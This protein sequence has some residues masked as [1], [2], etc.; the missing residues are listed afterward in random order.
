[1]GPQT[2]NNE[3]I[4]QYDPKDHRARQVRAL[5]IKIG[6]NS[7]SHAGGIEI[8]CSTRL[9]VRPFVDGVMMAG[10]DHHG[11]SYRTMID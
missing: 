8:A 5:Q 7:L 9:R 6:T 1:M 10:V 3:N 2:R 4:T 11:E